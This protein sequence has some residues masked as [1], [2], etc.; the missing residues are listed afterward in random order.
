MN[1]F[2][3]KTLMQMQRIDTKINN[4]EFEYNAMWQSAPIGQHSKIMERTSQKILK[5]QELRA[6]LWNKIRGYL[7]CNNGKNTL[8]QK[9]LEVGL[10]VHSYGE[11]EY[12][13]FGAKEIR[14]LITKESQ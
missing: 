1:K 2:I 8:W 11:E 6:P 4:L 13:L 12:L 5:L 14:E 9:A 10:H 7:V 3:E